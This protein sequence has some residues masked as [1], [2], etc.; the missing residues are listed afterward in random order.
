MRGIHSRRSGAQD[1]ES[2]PGSG[3]ID[4]VLWVGAAVVAVLLAAGR[5]ARGDHKKAPE[6]PQAPPE[7]VGATHAREAIEAA[8]S[9]ETDAIKRAREGEDPAGDLAALANMARR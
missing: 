3:V 7:G 9:E 2:V 6:S 5:F 8:L 1:G 4:S